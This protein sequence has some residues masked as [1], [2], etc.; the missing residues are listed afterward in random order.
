M[1]ITCAIMLATVMQVVDITIANVALPHMQGSLLAAQDQIAW[2]LT[3]YIVATAI[4][5]PLTGWLAARYGRKQLFL[6]SVA[7]F[8]AAS[9]LC[10]M[11]TTLPQIVL[12]R[13]VQG[14]AGAALMPLSQA[15]MLDINPKEKYA[16]A[17][18]IWGAGTMVGPILGPV[19]GAWLTEEYSW[20]WVF[21]INLPVGILAFL[22]IA[23]FLHTSHKKSTLPFD[24]IGFAT[25][26]LG[27]GGLQLMLD[28]GESK[29]WFGSPEICLE[30]GVAALAF[31]LFAVH[32]ATTRRQC[33]LNRALLKDPNFLIGIVFIFFVG[34]AVFATMA[35]TSP[36]MQTLLGYPVLTNGLLNAPR[37]IGTLATILVVGRLNGRIDN[38]VLILVGFAL[39]ALALWQMSHFS[40]LMG[41][42]PLVITGVIQGLGLGLTFIP[43]SVLTYS[44]L[45]SHLRTEGT[46]IFALM[47]NLGSSVGISIVMTLLVR[48]TQ[49]AHAALVQH[50]RPDNPVVGALSGDTLGMMNAEA[51][52]Q[53][54]MIA[55]NDD[56]HLLMILCLAIIP[57]LLL[58]RTPRGRAAPAATPMAVD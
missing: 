56:F 39:N 32:T 41:T 3:S 18:A 29:D 57:L 50:L 49:T 15:V 8:T 36:L 10:G 25:L 24:F 53:A 33:F 22:G 11:A 13:A 20:R 40:L 5:T 12:F 21:L 35:L 48:N 52:R 43:V 27:M 6:A 44:T 9:A 46:A 38:R 42:A 51:T 23:A 34:I 31:Y 7:G 14:A 1:L 45:A 30:A 2:V 26:S 4:A 17:M 47:R 58:M 54:T 28:R 19:L 55:F 37:G 16:Q